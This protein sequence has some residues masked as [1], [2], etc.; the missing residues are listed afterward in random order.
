MTEIVLAYLH[1][2]ALIGT[3]SMLVAAHLIVRPGISGAALQRIRVVDG[4]YGALATAAL[5]TGLMRVFWGAK[6]SAYYFSN[7]VFHAKFGVF[8]LAA[9]L[10][11]WPTVCFFRWSRA[12]LRDTAFAPPPAALARVRMLMRVQLLLLLTLPLLGAAMARGITRFG[13]FFA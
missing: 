2:L 3:V 6:G 9:L 13:Q 5:V 1:F 11:I 8:V 4:V 10:S 12:A 7:G